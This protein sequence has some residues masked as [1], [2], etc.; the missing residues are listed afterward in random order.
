MPLPQVVE[1]LLSAGSDCQL[2]DYRAASALHCAAAGGHKD[3]CRLLLDAGARVSCLR[4]PSVAV[5]PF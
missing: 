3:A 1:L 4:L 5:A 2:V